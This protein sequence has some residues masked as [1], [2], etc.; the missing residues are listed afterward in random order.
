VSCAS[1]LLISE[2]GRKFVGFM[3]NETE[4]IGVTEQVSDD[5]QLSIQ[6]WPYA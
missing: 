1:I 2:D 3:I 6:R 5:N 4:L